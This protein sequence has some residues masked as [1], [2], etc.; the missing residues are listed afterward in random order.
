MSEEANQAMV[1]IPTYIVFG[2]FFLFFL[3][4][5]IT[6][7]FHPT[8]VGQL[9]S[10]FKREILAFILAFGTTSLLSE[11]LHF[12]GVLERLPP[13]ERNFFHHLFYI[14]VLVILTVTYGLLLHDLSNRLFEA[15]ERKYSETNSKF[16][17][18][19]SV[20]FNLQTH[21]DEYKVLDVLLRDYKRLSE[22][23]QYLISL[24]AY[25]EL[26]K[27][28]FR[29][30]YEAFGTNDLLPPFWI[31][32]DF[33]NTSLNEYIEFLTKNKDKIKYERISVFKDDSTAN[34]LVGFAMAQI[35]KSDGGKAETYLWVL[36]LVQS[37]DIKDADF[38]PATVITSTDIQNSLV[39]QGI[40]WNIGIRHLFNSP[41]YSAI[42]NKDSEIEEKLNW[43]RTN[44]LA[45]ANKKVKEQ[46]KALQRGDIFYCPKELFNQR[47]KTKYNW[48]EVVIFENKTFDR[49]VGIAVVNNI[50]NAIQIEVMVD[51]NLLSLIKQIMSEADFKK[52]Y[53]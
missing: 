37:L 3:V 2:V 31:A 26:I 46:F 13:T 20:L 19:Y 17:E 35:E 33:Q 49:K 4:V 52:K 36:D 44:L 10:K 43:F 18:Y 1:Q 27:N 12:E 30:G 16:A 40:S 9:F 24:D 15:I 47:I 38:A 8:K 41:S 23:H 48:A 42:H 45:V 29:E 5:V 21:N 14:I 50:D 32:P 7:F 28:F 34:D 22:K 6:L 11:L 39:I 25:I 53:E 51:E